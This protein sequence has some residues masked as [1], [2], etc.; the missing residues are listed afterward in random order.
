MTVFPFPPPLASFDYTT[1]GGE[2]S[3]QNSSEN[4]TVYMWD[5]GDGDTSNAENP[6]HTYNNSD[7]YTV[8]LTASSICGDD[9]DSTRVLI[10]T[11]LIDWYQTEEFMIY[12]NP[13]SDIVFLKFRDAEK[14]INT[15]QVLDLKGNCVKII[16]PEETGDVLTLELHGL[17]TGVYFIKV[18]KDEDIYI[19]RLKLE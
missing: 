8:V 5:F 2:I 3:L 15:I 16:K 14:E 18:V 12:P 10:A 7:E 4:S 19:G 6:I 9:Q 13:A 1:S 17:A 11:S